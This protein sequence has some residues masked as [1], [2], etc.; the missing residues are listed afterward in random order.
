MYVV[1]LFM[2]GIYQTD[3]SLPILS[4]NNFVASSHWQLEGGGERKQINLTIDLL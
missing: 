2:C 1:R 4:S 3:D